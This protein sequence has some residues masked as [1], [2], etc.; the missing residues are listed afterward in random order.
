MIEVLVPFRADL[1]EN[2]RLTVFRSTDRQIVE[3]TLA[4]VGVPWEVQ[5]APPEH[6]YVADATY[7]RK[8]NTFINRALNDPEWR[9]DGLEFDNV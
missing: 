2:T 3:A 6:H 5:L 9:G 4:A 1:P 8:C 7:E